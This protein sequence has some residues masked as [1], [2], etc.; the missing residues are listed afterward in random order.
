MPHAA[1]GSGGEGE[2]SHRVMGLYPLQ[3][4]PV[5]GSLCSCGTPLEKTAVGLRM[6][7]VSCV[8]TSAYPGGPLIAHTSGKQAPASNFSDMNSSQPLQKQ[9]RTANVTG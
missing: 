3:C 4:C 7:L 5:A 2:P 8:E 9:Q 1:G 6:R